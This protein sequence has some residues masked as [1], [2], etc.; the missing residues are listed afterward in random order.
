MFLRKKS[1]APQSA[2]NHNIVFDSTFLYPRRLNST[3]NITEWTMLQSKSNDAQP[4]SRR[5]ST[6]GVSRM[7]VLIFL[8]I[9]ALTAQQ[10]GFF[11][12]LLT[13]DDKLMVLESKM[14][15]EASRISDLTK[16]LIRLEEAVP[17]NRQADEE[18]YPFVIRD[19]RRLADIQVDRGFHVYDYLDLSQADQSSRWSK[20]HS[21]YLDGHKIADAPCQEYSVEC[22]KLKILQSFRT[23]LKQSS[24][25]YF[26]YMESDNDLCVS[27]A[28]IRDLALHHRRYFLATG[29]GFS[30]WI[31]S[32]GFLIDFLEIYGNPSTPACPDCVGWKLMHAAGQWSVTRPYLVSHSIQRGSGSK[33]L[34]LSSVDNG[35]PLEK[36]L[37]RCFEPHR[38]KWTDAKSQGNDIYGWDYFD[39]EACPD[40]EIYPCSSDAKQLFYHKELYAG[41]LVTESP[42]SN[43][44]MT[45]TRRP[46]IRTSPVST[47]MELSS[48]DSNSSKRL[49]RN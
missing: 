10:M 45:I 21:L 46:P 35:K 12:N 29:I 25:D 7:G 20:K 33:A 32:R 16:R 36:H 42:N 47:K 38:A 41:A 27:L 13:E 24:A 11:T 28:E 14:E 30:G 48:T 9:G 4:S 5:R 26:F 44:T 43:S 1:R 15:K 23:V 34:T 19:S 39:Y 37:P 49:L 6:R 8:S 40:S 31:M 3:F 22:Y 18:F 2:V 17:F